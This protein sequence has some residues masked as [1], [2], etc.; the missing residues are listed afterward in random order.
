MAS[1]TIPPHHAI[2]CDIRLNFTVYSRPKSSKAIAHAISSMCSVW[3]ALLPFPAWQTPTHPSRLILNF[4]F[5]SQ[6]F[7]ISLAE[8]D[9]SPQSSHRTMFLTY[10][11]S[12]NHWCLCLQVGVSGDMARADTLCFCHFV[13]IYS[14]YFWQ[15]CPKLENKV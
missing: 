4:Y 14:S 15:Q 8:L 1:C 13:L 5:L 12:L 10:L 3:K 9:T 6:S 7:P 11:T 2:C